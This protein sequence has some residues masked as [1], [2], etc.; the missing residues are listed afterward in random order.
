MAA[1]LTNARLAT[2]E[3]I[4]DGLALRVAGGAIDAIAPIESFAESDDRVVDLSGALITPGLID[5]Q[6]NG[7]G[8]VM[9]CDAPELSTLEKMVRAHRPYGTTAMLPTLITS[10]LDIM[11]RTAEAVNEALQSDMPGIL[12]VHFEGPLLNPARKGVHDHTLFLRP[13][14]EVFDILTSIQGGKTLVTL[15]PEQVGVDMIS[16]L[17][18]HG[19]IVSIGHTD[20]TFEQAQA[21]FAAGATCATHLFNAMPPMLGRA[22]GP[23]AAAAL[24]RNVYC[25][26]IVDGHH[27]DPASMRF[28]VRA[29][30]VP[31]TILVTD[32]MSNVGADL[33]D[34]KLGNTE[35]HYSD[36]RLATAEG[37][38]A[39][40]ALSM[41]EA[42]R[43]A[44]SM[45]DL[46][47]EEVIAMATRSP[48]ELL[49]LEGALG[50]LQ[51]GRRADL[52]VFD[53]QLQVTHT[54]VAGDLQAH[55]FDQGRG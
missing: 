27:V 30:G 26:L 6:V 4:R 40:S 12:G 7:G 39:G 10:D 11:R 54:M 34:F 24:D 28:A 19:V 18:S 35:V 3:G 52:T 23:V 25:G 32:A 37:T 41:A 46:L 8:G 53:E 55:S 44:V 14:K 43:N 48:A 47:P 31:R 33:C 16:E 9:L 49:G 22:P 42:V 29:N 17:V 38:L 51:V 45:L 1:L 36:G 21:A 13:E 50:T 5:V 15:A 20:C 2:P